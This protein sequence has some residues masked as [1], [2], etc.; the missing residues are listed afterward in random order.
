MKNILMLTSGNV[1]RLD[2]FKNFDVTLG[3]FND[4]NFVLGSGKVNLKEQD[5]TDFKLIYFRFIGKSFEVA[6]LVANFARENGIQ[7]VDKIYEKSRLLAP[8]LGKSLE[9]LKL[10]Q[11]DI[12]MPKTVFG[13]LSKLPFPF[14]VKSTTGQRAKEVWL[15]N[16]EIEMKDLSQKLDKHKFYFAQ[17]FI[18]NAKRIR[19]LVVGEKVVGGIV[20]QT[21][22]NKDETKE[23]LNPISQEIV[24]LSIKTA[25]AVNLDICGVDILTNPTGKYWVIEANAAPSWNLINMYCG[26]NVE[27]EIIKYLQTKI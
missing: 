15:I 16:S 19:T 26:V 7:I 3:S 5:L 24:D 6:S 1:S 21:K 2:N 13:N 27:N 25:K 23:T 14:V 22:W 12:P 11:T 18:S 20:R 8:S 4:I 17:E 10:S 9:L